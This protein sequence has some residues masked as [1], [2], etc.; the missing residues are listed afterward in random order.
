M[1]ELLGLSSNAEAVYRAALQH[2]DHGVAALAV[3]TGLP[4][5]AIRE[6]FDQL[7]ALALLKPS[8]QRQGMLRAVSPDV[9]LATLLAVAEAELATRQAQVETTRAEITAIAAEHLGAR[10]FDNVAR[11]EGIDTVR[12]R[13]EELQ[14]TTEIE[15]LSLNPG[16]AHRPDARNAATP[17]NEEALLRGVTIRA[18]CRDSF[19]NDPDTLAYARWLIERGGQMRTVPT[20]PIQMVIVDRRV[21]IIPLDPADPRTGA[22]EIHS[23][24]IMTALC[25]LFEQCWATGTAYG[26]QPPSDANGCTPTE[27]ALLE[28]IAAGDTDESAARKLGVSLRTVRRMMSHLMDRLDAASRFQA[29]VNA[30][31]RRWL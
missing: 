23:P 6:A 10:G 15:C 13:L 3:E 31:R 9:G 29:G 24:G 19:R 17:L 28:I 27:R 16:G 8:D 25:A 11:L 2:P 21:A 14:R 18:V 7:A 1:L 4:E 22:L 30:S 12:A 20:V 26:E 5:K